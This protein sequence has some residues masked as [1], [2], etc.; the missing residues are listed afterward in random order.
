LDD[1][2]LT[3]SVRTGARTSLR[4]LRQPPP[5]GAEVAAVIGAGVV[6]AA[7]EAARCRGG[8]LR[9]RDYQCHLPPSLQLFGFNGLF[10]AP[11]RKTGVRTFSQWRTC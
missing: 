4:V 6:V 11:R 5:T 2:V 9:W 10:V 3:P 1:L 8:C 7:G